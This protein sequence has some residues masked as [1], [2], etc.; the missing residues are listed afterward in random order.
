MYKLRLL[1]LELKLLFGIVLVITVKILVFPDVVYADDDSLVYVGRT[2]NEQMGC[3]KEVI[4]PL[5]NYANLP[6]YYYDSALFYKYEIRDY[7]NSVVAYFKYLY[8]E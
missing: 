5:L 8:N 1:F 3:T 6:E 4:N 2:L 7:D